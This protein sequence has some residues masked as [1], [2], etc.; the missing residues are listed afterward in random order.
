[1]CQATAA[2][3]CYL[4]SHNNWEGNTIWVL[5]KNSKNVQFNL[6]NMTLQPDVA[7]AMVGIT[8][9]KMNLAV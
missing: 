8:Q 3:C 6:S 5:S 1:M 2:Y 4:G 9:A 7:V